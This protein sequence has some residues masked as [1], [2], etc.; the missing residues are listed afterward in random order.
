MARLDIR[1][2]F[3]KQTRVENE[4]YDGQKLVSISE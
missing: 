4:N 1:T 2:S 3:T